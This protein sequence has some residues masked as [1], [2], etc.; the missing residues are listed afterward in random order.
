MPVINDRE[1][2]PTRHEFYI[3]LFMYALALFRLVR[4][5]VTRA[6]GFG[7]EG[8]EPWDKSCVLP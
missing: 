4:A 7:M 2:N 8:K 1:T 6:R 3:R 5:F